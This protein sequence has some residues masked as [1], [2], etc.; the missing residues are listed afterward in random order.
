M[1]KLKKAVIALSVA[2]VIGLVALITI[3]SVWAASNQSLTSQLTVRYTA[4]KNV[5]V[6]VEAAYKQAGE[7]KY[8]HIGDTFF[9]GT[10]SSEN[11]ELTAKDLKFNTKSQSVRFWYYFE[12][13]GESAMTISLDNSKFTSTNMTIK[14]YVRHDDVNP[15]PS[16]D[17]SISFT[18]TTLNS[19]DLNNTDDW[20]EV[21]IEISVT[22][23][24]NDASFAGTITWNM[25][26]KS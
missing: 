17:S 22:D 12:N 10:D 7:T 25:S 20:V 26:I 4:A 8:T 5:S 15:V 19:I 6:A 16:N 18:Q 23:E 13:A 11:R 14:Y 2:V 3:V 24:M 1:S 9:N 21:Y